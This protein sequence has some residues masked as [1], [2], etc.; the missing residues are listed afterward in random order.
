MNDLTEAWL[1]WRETCE[2]DKCSPEHI[3]QLCVVSNSMFRRAVQKLPEGTAC[4]EQLSSLLPDTDEQI[5]EIQE[6]NA[7][8][9]TFRL[10]ECELLPAGEKTERQQYKDRI[11]NRAQS[12]GYVTGY[13]LRAFFRSYVKKKENF[14]YRLPELPE[15]SSVEAAENQQ[16]NA[17]K[18][19]G[20]LPE[21]KS[22]DNIENELLPI[23]RDFWSTLDEKQRAAL[24]AYHYHMTLSDSLLL[25]KV[26]GGKSVFSAIPAQQ[27]KRLVAFAKEKYNI[28]ERSDFYRLCTDAIQV[29]YDEWENESELG[30]WIVEH[31]SI[32]DIPGSKI[33]FH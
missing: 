24:Y 21:Q 5:S 22:P 25:E 27:I 11:F 29:C 2:L 30:R 6:R 8:R 3:N 26:G 19:N 7:F 17:M 32:P 20:D 14:S 4:I 16:H 31:S 1:D 23:A 28:T 15:G 12:P 9:H 10:M 33:R 18:E 13:F